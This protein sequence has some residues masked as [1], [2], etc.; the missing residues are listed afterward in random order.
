MAILSVNVVIKGR[1]QP[2]REVESREVFL[3]FDDGELEERECVCVVYY[4][5]KA[6]SQ[7]N[8]DHHSS[9]IYSRDFPGGPV[10]NTL[11]FQGRGMGLSPGRGAKIPHA[12][13]SGQKI[14]L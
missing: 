6:T 14:K 5:M 2:E 11:C 4:H 9:I 13:W 3:L 7:C 1:R 12:V 10:V 8:K